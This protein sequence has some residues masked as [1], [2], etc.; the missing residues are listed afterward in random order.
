MK[1]LFNNSGFLFSI[2]QRKKMKNKNLFA[3]IV[4]GTLGLFFSAS[5]TQV[6][7]Q[8]PV[9]TSP[10][11]ST[12]FD[13]RPHYIAANTSLWYRFDYT[14]DKT[15]IL[16]KMFN[17]AN[18]GL[19]YGLWSPETSEKPFGRGTAKTI[20]CGA[21]KCEDTDLTWKGATPVRGT[22]FLQVTNTTVKP[23]T[24]YLVMAGESVTFGPTPVPDALSS[25][26]QAPSNVSPD[27]AAPL[28]N[29]LLQ[30]A[31]DNT[32]LWYRFDYN[33][34]SSPIVISL[35]D[36]R[37]SDVYFR[38]YTADPAKQSDTNGAYVGQGEG[39]VA[40][41]D[42]GKCLLG[43]LSWAGTLPGPGTYFV[44]VYNA[45]PNAIFFRLLME[46]EGISPGQP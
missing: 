46:G 10:G 39:A 28:Q 21:D 42:N 15:L 20:P 34:N 11:T 17:A 27:A 40:N 29:N 1:P 23:L 16:T 6:Y 30:V 25:V 35:A 24:F 31:P 19:D 3:A 43:D 38:V 26:L 41:C 7:A 44:Q 4:L 22:Y 5:S 36:G 12:Y 8:G 32:S 14:G 13:N 37:R 9:N 18:T 2:Y 33:S 45:S